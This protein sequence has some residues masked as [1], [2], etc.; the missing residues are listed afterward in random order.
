[1]KNNKNYC[2]FVSQVKSSQVK[3]S[4]KIISLI[5]LFILLFSI[6]CKSNEKPPEPPTVKHE[7]EGTWVGYDKKYELKFTV[8]SDGNITLSP[9]PYLDKDDLRVPYNYTGKLTVGDTFNYPFTA[10]VSNYDVYVYY[11]EEGK[12][13]FNNSTNCTANYFRI[14]G[15]KHDY[16]FQASQTTVEFTKQ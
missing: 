9:E 5:A 8:D 4:A 11:D 14:E 1:M 15:S 6:S 12:L 10:K 16:D 2:K 7:L 3:S 13:T